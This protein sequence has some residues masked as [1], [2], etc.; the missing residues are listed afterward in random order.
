MKWAE[1]S[2]QTLNEATEAVANIFHEL[3]ASGVVI[4]D[5][6]LINTYRRSGAWDYCDI[7]EQIENDIVTIK[8]YLP[9]DDCLDDKIRQLSGALKDLEK[10]IEKQI[11]RVERREVQEEDWAE[12]WKEY[13]FPVKVG[14]RVVI[15]PTWKEYVK[16]DEELVIEI[17]PGMAFGTGSHHTTS[18]C[19]RM[20]EDIVK[21]DDLVYDVGTGSGILAVTAAKLGA[22]QVV[23]VDND[24]V[25]VRVAR[26]NVV[27][28]KV[29]SQVMVNQG[30]ILTGI[31]GKAD[32]IVANI[33]ADIILR[34]LPDVPERLADGGYFIAGGIIVERVGEVL[35]E[36]SANGLVLEKAI[37]E[38]GWGTIMARKGG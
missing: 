9:V 38:G 34:M 20:L 35:L 10:N 16:Q 27:L 15:K 1:L 11:G 30:D 18:M 26:E 31:S 22:R 25:A 32:I 12:A 7:P 8:A 14:E 23:A 29:D 3:G 36:L 33:I 28:N 4:E 5:P 2:I 13:F 19:I 37:E 6:A 21:P 17:D 24:S